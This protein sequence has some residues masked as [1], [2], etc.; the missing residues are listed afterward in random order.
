MGSTENDVNILV[1][2]DDSASQHALQHVFDSEGW[3]VSVVP[4]PSEAMREL[5]RGRWA[6]V[7]VNVALADLTGPLFA[8]LKTLAQA[9]VDAD[10]E[11]GQRLLRVLFLVPALAARWAQPVLEREG[12]P[13]VGKPFHLHD[14]LEK[15]S[16]LLIEAKAI[17]RPIRDTRLPAIKERRQKDRRSGGDR[18][19]GQMFASREDYMMTEEEIAEYER[20]EEDERK[21]RQE[22]EK[23][24]DV[25]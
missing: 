15:V 13:F 7:V 11:H 23:K 6:L 1:I 9:E 22:D 20:Q 14:F 16:D 21:K 24:R 25:L 19:R 5:A 3:R 2:D 10:A 12:L 18:R 17:P 8:T 4:I